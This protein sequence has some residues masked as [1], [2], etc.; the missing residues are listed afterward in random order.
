MHLSKEYITESESLGR[1]EVIQSRSASLVTTALFRIFG[2]LLEAALD[3]YLAISHRTFVVLTSFVSSLASELL[4]ADEECA[5]ARS[6]QR[7]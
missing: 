1:F 3:C 6:E 2:R 7:V 4:R 5:A